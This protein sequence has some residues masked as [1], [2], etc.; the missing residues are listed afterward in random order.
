MDQRQ[1]EDVRVEVD[2]GRCCGNGLCVE[3]APGYFGWS[4]DGA[5]AQLRT[6]AEPADIPEIEEAIVC[7]PAQAISLFGD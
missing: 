2:V 5:L 4:S 7:C 3:I 1:E 6:A